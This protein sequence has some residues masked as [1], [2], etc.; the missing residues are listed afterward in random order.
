MV[1]GTVMARK[2]G[3]FFCINGESQKTNEECHSF[4][5]DFEILKM[6]I[7]G[8]SAKEVSERPL[9]LLI[10]FCVVGNVYQK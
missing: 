1:G 7:S 8:R 3:T 6:K 10:I 5:L 2:S 4:E 9:K